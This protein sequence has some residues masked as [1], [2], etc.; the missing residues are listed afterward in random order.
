MKCL[1]I[2]SFCM[3]FNFCAASGQVFPDGEW[4]TSDP[5]DQ[6]MSS[7]GLSKAKVKFKKTGGLAMM[8]IRNG[9]VVAQWGDVKRKF[10]SRSIR[11]SL[12]NSL[13]GIQVKRGV[14]DIEK[15]LSE[16]NV[17]DKT[18]LN[19]SEYQARFKHLLSSSS[20]V[21]LPASFEQQFHIKNKPKR[22]SHVPG[23]AFFYNNWSFNVIASI[24][25]EQTGVDLFQSFNKEIAI[26]LQME[27][28]NYPYDVAY[29][30]QPA[31]S[32]HPAY[33][34]RMSTRDLARYAL[35]FL[36]DGNWD[37]KQI[38]DKNW[39][40]ESTKTQIKTGESLYYDYGYLWWVTKGPNEKRKSFL[41][42]GAQSQYLY[43]DPNSNLIIVFRDNPDGTIQVKK[44][45]AYPLIGDVYRSFR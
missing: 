4:K 14:I 18:Q 38:V 40:I 36:N 3:V 22:S 43:V 2:I 11:K 5:E 23:E 7:S 32:K 24:Y 34:F 37:G 21:Y 31:L 30:N 33:L 12:I 42:R 9:Y 6:K 15:K 25:N 28:F 1:V 27:D 10:D 17:T 45:E 19:K 39:V 35:L 44:R 29:L 20:A 41:A 16:L 8:V 26:P 13:I